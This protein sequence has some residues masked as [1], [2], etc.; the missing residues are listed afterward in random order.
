MQVI[1][2]SLGQ[3]AANC[4]FL[5]KDKKCLIIDPADEAAFILE[6]IVR[7]NLELVGMVATHGHFD[8]IMAAGEIQLSYDVPLY[9]HE[10]DLFLVKRM[11]STAKHFLGHN[12]HM[13][14][15]KRIEKLQGR[16]ERVGPFKFEMIRTP[17]HTPGSCCFV[18]HLG[19]VPQAQHHLRG[20]RP[21][22]E[23]E[24]TKKILFSGDTLFK[25]GIGRY[26]FSYSSFQDL[27]RSLKKLF[28][29]PKNTL[30]Y[31]G[32]GEKTTIGEER[33]T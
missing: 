23:D 4:Y 21:D 13:L 20:G 33:K 2:F 32:H 25:S 6:K 24:R 22:V 26:D 10:K 17:G 5:V 15:P 7:E 1:K 8:H 3:L 18:F 28:E 16:T 19:G 12:P 11:Q 9:I 31:P 30:V 14:E 27:Q 29:M